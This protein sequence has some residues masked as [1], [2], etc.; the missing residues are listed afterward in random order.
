MRSETEKVCAVSDPKK[1]DKLSH[2]SRFVC[3]RCGATAHSKSNV[4]VPVFM[5][6][7]H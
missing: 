2:E 4:C 5:E 3:E 1:L 6:P 7:D